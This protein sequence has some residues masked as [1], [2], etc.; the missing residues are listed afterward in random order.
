MRRRPIPPEPLSRLAVWSLRIVLFALAA[1][2]AA[3]ILVRGEFIEALAGQS[4]L[5]AALAVAAIGIVYA[6]GAFV[7]IW[8][9][10]NPG[11]G[12]AVLA[13]FLGAALLA[14]PAF[15]A[16]R[17]YKLP[18]IADV[19]TDTGDPPAFEVI[20]RIRPR[21]ANPVQYPGAETAARQRA[22]YPA[23]RTLR[24]D[25]RPL[26][27]YDSALDIVNKRKWRIVD[28][29]TPLPGR[30]DGRIEAVAQTP[31]MGFRD[32]VVIRV[33]GSA[34]NAVVDIRSASRYGTRDWGSNA[35]RIAAL[36]SEIEEETV[37]I[38]R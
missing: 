15:V 25:A 24:L 11:L 26:A 17:G 22:A 30:R 16:V 12:R 5:F 18:A 10:G 14:Y 23:L 1:S 27:A 21:G 20:A 32:D 35:R 7:V 8:R 6:L 28:F 31:V 2:L 4:V 37:Q 19:A 34:N 29:R 13:L 9:E 36:L 38:E 33:R 3:V